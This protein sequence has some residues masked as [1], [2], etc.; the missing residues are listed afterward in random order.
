M[1]L[2][3]VQ[4]LAYGCECCVRLFMDES[5]C[6]A[7]ERLCT[8]RIVA[9]VPTT[10]ANTSTT[11]D[12]LVEAETIT[13]VD[14]KSPATSMNDNETDIQV[15]TPLFQN[16]V[17]S[18]VV[19]SNKSPESV[20]SHAQNTLS[21]APS[22]GGLTQLSLE[23][24]LSSSDNNDVISRNISHFAAPPEK[25]SGN[26]TLSY[27]KSKPSDVAQQHFKMSKTNAK[28]ETSKKVAT[29]KQPAPFS[30][31]H[32]S[33]RFTRRDAVYRHVAR[34]HRELRGYRCTI[35]DEQFANKREAEAHNTIVHKGVYFTCGI[36][37]EK[38]TVA[39]SYHKHLLRHRQNEKRYACDVND[40]GR[41]FGERKLLQ[42]HTV[43]V[44]EGIV[45]IVQ[46]TQNECYM[47][48]KIMRGICLA[49]Q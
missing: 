11:Y 1:V 35:C 15:I 23:S 46:Y 48:I 24:M 22:S 26:D 10:E 38:F 33:E 34:E 49:H 28:K 43:R 25:K 30:C 7:H 20:T 40:C 29:P 9:A 45:V 31:K 2:R 18:L 14:V 16:D 39:R 12:E 44:S 3:I 36:C 5:V 27:S 17:L 19:S 4:S 41:V 8:A 13:E 47:D 6:I 42:N 37:G 32:C 21:I